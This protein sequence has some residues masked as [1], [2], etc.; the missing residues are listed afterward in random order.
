MPKLKWNGSKI[1]IAANQ[2]SNFT[3]LNDYFIMIIF[4]QA[5]PF[6]HKHF[7]NDT[8]IRLEG[9]EGK[10]IEMLSQVMDFTFEIVDCGRVWGNK[11]ANGSWSGIIGAVHEKVANQ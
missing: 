3:M 5:P 7:F 11:L 9:Y 6:V 2:V 10:I 4:Q 1:Y 8:L